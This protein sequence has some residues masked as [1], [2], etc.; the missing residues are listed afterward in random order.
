MRILLPIWSIL[1]NAAFSDDS[2]NSNLKL[3]TEV[4]VHKQDLTQHKHPF[5]V[6]LSPAKWIAAKLSFVSHK[7][8]QN[9]CQIFMILIVY[10]AR[11]PFGD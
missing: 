9:C 8:H 2:Y 6:I 10:I 11:Q 4:F 5:N 7:M 3:V 1:L